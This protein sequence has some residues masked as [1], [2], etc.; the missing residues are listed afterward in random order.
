MKKKQER[1]KLAK[2]LERKISRKKVEA[3]G[4]AALTFGDL[5]Y[6][7][8]RVDQRYIMGAD[9]ARPSE[10]LSSAFKLGKQ[11]IRDIAE[12]GEA[13]SDHLHNVNYKGYTHEFV[14][15]QWMRSQDVE[16]ELPETFNQHAWD[17]IYN[18]QKWQI[19]FG[20]VENVRKARLENPDIPVAT[21]LESAAE[22]REKFPEDVAWVLGTTPRSF[23]EK[24]VA[25]GQEASI[26]IHEDEELFETG[27]PEFLGIASIV[28]LIKNVSYLNDK[29][30]DLSTGAQNVAIDTAGRATAMWGGAKIGGAILGPI[31]AVAGAIGGGLFSGK[32]IEDFKLFMFCEEETDQLKK[33]LDNYLLRAK[34][35]LQKNQKTFE[36][37]IKKLKSTIGTKAFRKKIFKEDKISKELFEYLSERMDA[38]HKS[39]GYMIKKLTW[40]TDKKFEDMSYKNN[41]AWVKYGELKDY[42]NAK[43]PE[44][45]RVAIEVC[46]EAGILPSFI[47]TEIKNL[48]SSVKKFIK[49]AEKRGI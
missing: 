2:F 5:I 12:K 20:S 34:K 26:E 1:S 22:Y 14:T 6:D 10:N 31:G 44:F 21:D 39:R 32:Y 47:Q 7:T 15:H 41:Y 17:A 40:A 9:L 46:S 29:K 35:I 49:V 13:Y 38:E 23:T 3:S 8:V 19:K 28:S 48:D 27:A 24:I 42:S 16:V 11:N 33:D 37:K 18:G 4:I 36:K 25:E 43:L 45:A 30:T